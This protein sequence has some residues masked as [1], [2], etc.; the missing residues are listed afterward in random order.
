[1]KPGEDKDKKDP[2]KGNTKHPAEKQQREKKDQP[3]KQDDSNEDDE[4]A[5]DEGLDDPEFDEF[6]E[7]GGD[8]DF[9]D[10]LKKAEPQ[11]EEKDTAGDAELVEEK[12]ESLKGIEGTDHHI[13]NVEEE[14]VNKKGQ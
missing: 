11:K 10:Q 7:N 12:E 8:D 3:T 14:I 1:M 6:D 2:K 5:F 4:N 13:T 9:R